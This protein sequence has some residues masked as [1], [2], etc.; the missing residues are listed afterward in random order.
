MLVS[1]QRPLQSHPSVLDWVFKPEQRRPLTSGPTVEEMP[2]SFS[3]AVDLP[4][5]IPEDITLRLENKTISLT[6]KRSIGGQGTQT[7]FR[8]KLPRDAKST[9]IDATLDHGVLTLTVPKSEQS[10]PK[11][12][13]IN[14][15]HA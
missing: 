4:G 3:V 5:V 14:L 15:A 2:E 10:Q 8:W 11:D 6:T 9:A 13:P 1:Y 12:I 7:H